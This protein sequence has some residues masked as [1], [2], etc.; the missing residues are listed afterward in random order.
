MIDEYDY[1]CTY[2]G[3]KYGA[4][5]I[6]LTVGLYVGIERAGQM[7]FFHSEHSRNEIPLEVTLPADA[8][9]VSGSLTGYG[10]RPSFRYTWGLRG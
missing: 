1:F 6:C 7:P 10:T 3:W 9:N 8:R 2:Y 5:V 4:R